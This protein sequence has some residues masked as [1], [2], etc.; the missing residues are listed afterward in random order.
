MGRRAKTN[1][2]LS[3]NGLVEQAL[4]SA[5]R[6]RA[7]YEDV[8]GYETCL[9]EDAKANELFDGRMVDLLG[10]CKQE[11]EA[12]DEHALMLFKDETGLTKMH[13]S[14]YSDDHKYSQHEN[15]VTGEIDTCGS[16]KFTEITGTVLDSWTHEDDRQFPGGAGELFMEMMDRTRAQFAGK[17][18]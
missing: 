2:F 17:A 5:E 10:G 11:N 12:V 16:F 1:A 7:L 18:V 14:G 3:L 13:A 9:R 6:G 4:V 8:L 15:S